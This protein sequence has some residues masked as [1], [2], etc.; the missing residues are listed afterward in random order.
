[1]CRFDKTYHENS[2]VVLSGDGCRAGV[3]RKFAGDEAIIDVVTVPKG[4]VINQ[5]KLQSMQTLPTFAL[6]DR[7]DI[8][9]VHDPKS[10]KLVRYD[11]QPQ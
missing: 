11:L 5:V 9:L 10:G 2:P 8:L 4:D 3:V 6:S 7:G 1:M